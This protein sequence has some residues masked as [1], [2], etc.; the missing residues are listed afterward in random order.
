MS[1]LVAKTGVVA[2]LLFTTFFQTPAMP[3]IKMG[4]WETTSTMNMSGMMSHMPGLG[5]RKNKVRACLTPESY[6][7]SLSAQQQNDCVR[8]NE[9]MNDKKMSFDLS[10]N[11]GRQTGH[12]ETF[13][14]GP[15]AAHSNM[16][17]SMNGAMTIDS[18]STSTFISTDCGA[19]TPEKPQIVK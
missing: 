7:K 19:V 17:M 16:H 8:S 1:F 14:D 4:L 11:G 5:S 6:A 9:V 12:V 3:P 10:C 15:D 2:G 18:A 13:F